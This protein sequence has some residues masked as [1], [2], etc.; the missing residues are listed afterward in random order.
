MRPA[1]EWCRCI[2]LQVLDIRAN[3][4]LGPVKLLLQPSEQ[5]ILFAFGKHQVI[6]RQ[7]TVLLLEFAL[8]FIPVAS[9]GEFVHASSSNVRP[10]M[11][12]RKSSPHRLENALLLRPASGRKC[13]FSGG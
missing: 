4:I 10:L 8:N 3:F 13:F 6:I 7:L 12:S 9:D 1:Q 2:I 5:L 11:R